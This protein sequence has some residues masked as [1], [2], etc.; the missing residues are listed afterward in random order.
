MGPYQLSSGA[1]TPDWRGSWSNSAEFGRAT[2]TGTINYVGG[3]WDYS[4]DTSDPTH[5]TDDASK[6]A[7]AGELYSPNFCKTKKFIDVDLV[8][9]YK[10]TPNVTIYGN[11]LNLFDAKAPIEP[12]NYAGAQVNY[13][14]TWAQAGA[15]GRAFRIGANFSFRPNPAPPPA[16][17]VMMPPPPPPPPATVTCE[18]GAVVTAPGVCPPPAAPPPPP[19][20]APVERGERG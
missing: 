9:S 20:P 8:A 4:E 11:V 13:N 14:P 2:V 10:L 15:I 1:G 12:A 17:P 19:P 3:Y 16:A 6:C 7:A 5:I 18:S